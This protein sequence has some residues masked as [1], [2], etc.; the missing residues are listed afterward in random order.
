MPM[1]HVAA[2]KPKGVRMPRGVQVVP[3]SALRYWRCPGTE[4]LE[5]LA[6]GGQDLHDQDWHDTAVPAGQGISPASGIRKTFGRAR[7]NVEVRC[8]PNRRAV[9]VSS[10]PSFTVSTLSRPEW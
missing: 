1:E 4:V 7:L 5:G 6:V 10:W 8:R 3:R 2:S 9:G